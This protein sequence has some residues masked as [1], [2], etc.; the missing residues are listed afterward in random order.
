VV[1]ETAGAED[2]VV[3]ILPPLTIQPDILEDGLQIVRDTMRH[4]VDRK[5]THAAA[6][7]LQITP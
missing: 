2:E 6:Q 3:K 4:V 1:I 7:S 5:S